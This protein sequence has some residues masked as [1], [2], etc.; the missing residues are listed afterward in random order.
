MSVSTL[1]EL[2]SRFHFKDKISIFFHNLLVIFYQSWRQHSW[3][4]LEISFSV[5]FLGA[6]LHPEIDISS[7]R[8]KPKSEPNSKRKTGKDRRNVH[9]KLNASWKISSLAI[10][11]QSFLV[12]DGYLW[13]LAFILLFPLWHTAVVLGRLVPCLSLGILLGDVLETAIGHSFTSCWGK[14]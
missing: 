9:G 4:W 5:S 2:F 10:N 11:G 6:S 3:A 1:Q 7:N 8:N 13:H 12:I 14:G